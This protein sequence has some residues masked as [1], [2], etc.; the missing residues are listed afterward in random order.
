MTIHL[1]HNLPAESARKYPNKEAVSF[2][3]RSITYADLES[4]SNQLAAALSAMGVKKGD[5]VGIML[6]KSIESIVALFGIMKT[7]A[8]YVPLDPLA[9]AGRVT[10]IISHCGIECLVTSS[11]NLKKICLETQTASPV[12]KAILT[13]SLSDDGISKHIACLLWEELEAHRLYFTLIG[14]SDTTPAYILHTSGSTGEPKGVVISHLNALTFVNMAAEV[15]SLNE[16]DRFANHAPLYFD[17]SV[18]DIFGAVKSGATIVLVPE[19]LSPFPAKL[20]EFIE[21]ERISVWNSVSSVLTMVADRG[22]PDR[23]GFNALRLVHFSGDVMPA[24]H[25]RVLKQH[26]KR[27]EFYNIYGQ[28][29]ANSSLFYPVRE[30][31]QD[32]TWKIP[33]GKPLPNFDVFALNER[34]EIIRQPGEKGELYVNSSTV[35]LGYWKNEAMTN[36][37]FVPDPRC[38][39]WNCCIYRTGDLVRLDKDGN[40]TLAGRK[41]H[42]IKSRGYRI[43]LGEIELALNSHP[44]VSQAIVI[45]MP[46]ELL[47]NRIIAYVTLSESAHETSGEIQAYCHTRLP[48]YMVPEE[49]FIMERMPRTATGKADRRMMAE[50]YS[51]RKKQFILNENTAHRTAGSGSDLVH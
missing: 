24:K 16:N 17:L 44:D 22:R 26:M 47:G 38:N 45:A 13:G 50:I 4:K 46:D 14:L 40:F 35:A 33:L 25:L 1:L 34:N 8:M 30:I 12:R 18:F 49:I 9:P 23:F 29:E 28:T 5:R 6:S 15:F 2:K 20:A 39:A 3:G 7:G 11:E 31:P 48:R 10:R 32:E 36:E 41:D 42:M 19:N 27:A 43:E 21:T 37:K 51:N